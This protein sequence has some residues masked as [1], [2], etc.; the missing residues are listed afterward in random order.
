M[1]NTAAVDSALFR[2]LT[3]RAK[4]RIPHPTSNAFD[5]DEWL[6][7]LPTD[8]S[9]RDETLIRTALLVNEHV[10]KLRDD[11][12]ATAFTGL[13]QAELVM[14][15]VACANRGFLLIRRKS[16][17]AVAALRAKT[18]AAHLSALA[19][20][21][22]IAHE[23]ASPQVGTDL[24][25]AMIDSLPHWF[26]A[27]AGLPMKK[28]EIDAEQNFSIAGAAG[29]RMFSLDNAFREIWQEV[30][31]EPWDI[32]NTIAD[33]R[34]AP[35]EPDDQAMWRVWDWRE[36]SVLHQGAV[37]NRHLE[38]RHPDI[39]PETPI[40]RTVQRFEADNPPVITLGQPSEDQGTLHRSTLDLL[41]DAYVA[42]FLDDAL[43]AG[44]VTPRLLARATLVLQ[45]LLQQA[46]P[47]EPDPK[48]F[49]AA[50]VAAMSCLMPRSSIVAT[51]ETSLA[52]PPALADA[53]TTFLTSNPWGELGPLFSPGIWHRPLITSEDGANLMIVAGALVWGSPLR[54]VERW[55]Q[56]GKGTDLTKSSNGLRFERELRDKAAASLVANPILAP[57]SSKVISVPGREGVEEIDIVLRIGETII[58][59]EI[60]CFIGPADPIERYDY[61]RKLEDAAEQA[62]R[63]ARWLDVNRNAA[64]EILPAADQ[65]EL[66]FVPLVIVNQSNGASWSFDGCTVVDA[67]W[68]DM[69]LSSGEYHTAATIALDG[70]SDDTFAGATL[71][72]TVAEAE[73]AIP[74]LFENHPGLRLFRDALDWSESIIPLADG[75]PLR[76]AYPVMDPVRYSANFPLPGVGGIMTAFDPSITEHAARES[77]SM[78]GNGANYSKQKGSWL[79]S[80]SLG[81]LIWSLKG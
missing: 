12:I 81:A 56:A 61:L 21:S 40:T 9:K 67:K 60:K 48:H 80:S 36:Q 8:Y 38:R 1:P 50:W 79:R 68:F 33:V 57:A 69:F 71:Y 58:V 46:I 15:A 44:G 74:K 25:T 42:I 6:S 63:K 31:W 62:R 27:A 72:T 41:E 45:D 14:L 76:M 17:E 34:V 66:R 7:V 37:F 4:P 53:L 13:S 51:L 3:G 28:G 2:H 39:E 10:R 24:N 49:D 11:Y 64:A 35:L 52:V 59:G 26:A 54:A 18:P 32:E 22:I 55:L 43:D 75:R 23:G 29:E 78:P 70:Q 77:R 73:A 19:Q 47:S 30:L 65:D 16:Y 20:V 5:F